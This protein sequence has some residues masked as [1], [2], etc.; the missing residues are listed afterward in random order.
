[1]GNCDNS[2][3]LHKKEKNWELFFNPQIAS[4]VRDLCCDTLCL[5]MVLNTKRRAQDVPEFRGK[6]LEGTWSRAP[7]LGRMA[8]LSELH[9]CKPSQASAFVEMTTELG[10]LQLLT[11]ATHHLT[12]YTHLCGVSWSQAGA[13][14][15]LRVPLRSW[16][17]T[18]VPDFGG[19][20]RTRKLKTRLR[21]LHRS[22]GSS[23][24]GHRL[25]SPAV[26]HR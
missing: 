15:V 4:W 1:M 7:G 13:R 18:M 19:E 2:K 10:H 6:P 20:G 3:H 14:T 21:E 9:H 24:F 5:D 23:L 16:Q 25:K 8:S 26:S 12:H 17:S 11:N 22:D